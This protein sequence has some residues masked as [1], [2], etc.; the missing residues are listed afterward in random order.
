MSK[1][2]LDEKQLLP[3]LGF[4]QALNELIRDYKRRFGFTIEHD[5]EEK[6]TTYKFTIDLE[7][8]QYTAELYYYYD[9]VEG[10]K[11]DWNDLVQQLNH[12]KKVI[13]T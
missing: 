11:N 5:S 4:C 10:E 7:L 3:V 9:E 6:T 2:E 12:I 1:E 8:G 13:T